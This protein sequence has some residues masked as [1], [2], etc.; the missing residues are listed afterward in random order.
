MPIEELKRPERIDEE[1]IEKLKEL[2]PEAFTDGVL[3]FEVFKEEVT[4][5]NNEN[6][7]ET[8]EEYYSFN[9][10]G[11]REARKLAFLSPQGTLKSSKDEGIDEKKT[12]NILIEGDNLEVLRILQ[13]SYSK[14]IKCIY[15]DPPYNTGKDF[16]YKDD[17]K[18]PV[19]KYLQKS[20]QADEE[21]LLTSN[22]K[23]SGRYHANWLNM[24][25]P[26]LKLARNLLK[27]D[28]VIFIS[29]DDN[30][31]AN[32]KQMMDEIF[33]E[34]NFVTN[35]VWQK[36]YSPRNDSTYF[37]DMHDYILVYAK[38]KKS[39]KNDEGGWERNLL[40]RS[41]R[42]ISMYK[43]PDNDPRGVWKSENLTVKSYSKD[44]DYPITVPSG[45]VVNPPSGRCWMTSKENYQKLV[46]DN[47]IWFGKDGN[48][49]PALKK[50]LSEVQNGTV[51]VTWWKR[52]ECGDNQEAT[53]ELRLMF[54]DTGV[55][56][57]TPKPVRLIKKILQLATT[58]DQNDI[59]LDFFAGSGTIAQAVLEINKEDSG[60]RKF[61]VVQ[62]P[63]PTE[64][65]YY[66]T[67][68]DVTK[69][70]IRRSI[71]KIKENSENDITL[72]QG[73]KVYHM[74]KTNFRKWELFK[75]ES[76]EKLNEQ[77][78]W[79]TDT[80]I[81]EN[82]VDIDIVTE[83]MLQ[84]GFPLDSGHETVNKYSNL[85]WMVQHEDVPFPLVVCLD[86][87]LQNEACE[88]LISDFRKG[89]FIC[90][91]NAL[92]NE[93]KILLSESMNVKTI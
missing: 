28:G 51:P 22:P 24:M 48:N 91:D 55:P 46:E 18:D 43:N 1:R 59:I 42:Q 19:E 84:Q 52:E 14:K 10:T 67:I 38:R 71:K 65:E 40:P 69:E 8:N 73:F 2:F 26:R 31:Q 57:E 30:E 47:R 82:A 85:L 3:N 41:E 33:G 89:T 44:Y 77:I 15:I 62:V 21:G 20:G 37:S 64:N 83:L 12:K 56:F 75:G 25:Y 88:F 68:A 70:R 72:D 29:I 60:N 17:F 7:E 6:N 36:N 79:I 92:S 78:E 35:I 61:I 90:F 16:V 74:E 23:A 87:T 27:E 86:E 32:L 54:E 50:F 34:E 13:K 66:S 53:K 45:R 80:P 76:S 81:K 63:E 11:K 58:P 5:L 39:K 4:A 93:Q 49:V 9:W